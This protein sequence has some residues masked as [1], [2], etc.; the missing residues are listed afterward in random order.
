M[1]KERRR[2]VRANCHEDAVVKLP[3]SF[4]ARKCTVEN[5][6]VDGVCLK[7]DGPQ[8][9]P[10]DFLLLP[11]GPRGPVRAC[12]VKWRR[13]NLIGAEYTVR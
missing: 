9:L 6:T 13:G 4:A 7:I 11:Q 10:E 3:S 2:K 1:K 12:H 8:F 5:R